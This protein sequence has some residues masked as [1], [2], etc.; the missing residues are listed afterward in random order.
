MCTEA[1]GGGTQDGDGWWVS[2]CVDGM[3][4]SKGGTLLLSLLFPEEATGGHYSSLRHWALASGAGSGGQALPGL[5][6][7]ATPPG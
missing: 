3:Q 4:A 5:P 7:L 1:G 6:G 2:G